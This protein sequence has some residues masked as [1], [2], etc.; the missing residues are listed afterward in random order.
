MSTQQ[1]ESIRQKYQDRMLELCL[2]DEAV[3]ARTGPPAPG[4]GTRLQVLLMLAAVLAVALLWAWP[5][6]ASETD[7]ARRLPLDFGIRDALQ[8]KLTPQLRKKLDDLLGTTFV[9]RPGI[10]GGTKIFIRSTDELLALLR[11]RP[12]GWPHVRERLPTLTRARACGWDLPALITVWLHDPIN[13]PKAE[14]LLEQEPGLLDLD[15]LLFLAERS[16]GK[17]R[18]RAEAILR[19]REQWKGVDGTPIY[20]RLLVD[21]YFLGR[22]DTARLPAVRRE[23]EKHEQ[24]NKDRHGTRFDDM[25]L[26]C[27][28]YLYHHG[29]TRPWIEGLRRLETEVEAQLR[30]D[31][32]AEVRL[33]R[34][35]FALGVARALHQYLALGRLP[36]L[37]DV[38]SR[39]Y[40]EWSEGMPRLG[41]PATIRATLAGLANLPPPKRR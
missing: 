38:L 13:R 15:H 39:S 35:E 11:R 33:Q 41:T 1:I 30:S 23:M 34:A 18:T 27:A 17:T 4:R 10:D 29:E 32:P 31:E 21:L 26:V 16:E 25:F 22:G 9:N 12:V 3:T 8:D 36:P 28:A 2:E 24:G 6:E 20:A 5:D 40:Y 37:A 14:A 7:D 19:S